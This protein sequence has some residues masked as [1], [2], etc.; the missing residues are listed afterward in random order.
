MPS[1]G[2]RASIS[3]RPR[4]I[5]DS[6]SPIPERA[7]RPA[8][9]RSSGRKHRSSPSCWVRDW[10]DLLVLVRRSPIPGLAL[11]GFCAAGWAW[12]Y[13]AGAMDSLDF[14]QP[15]PTYLRV[16]FGPGDRRS[17]RPRGGGQTPPNADRRAWAA[18]IAGSLAGFLLV[19]FRVLGP[20]L[21]GSVRYHLWAGE[22]FLS[23]RPSAQLSGS[24]IGSGDTSSPA[25][26]CCMKKAARTCPTPGHPSATGDSA[27][28]C[29]GERV[30][31]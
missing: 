17:C 31:R 24:S 5:A 14:L 25:S 30:S 1:G 4:E 23:S 27:A 2:C 10:P 18:W 11:A 26:G 21:A 7:W 22:P 28:F 13:L 16:L 12:G 9:R 6:L 29:P 15:G 3:L 19:A 20:S 8:W